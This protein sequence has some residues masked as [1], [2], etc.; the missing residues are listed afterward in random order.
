MTPVTATFAGLSARGEG[1]FGLLAS[2]SFLYNNLWM[3]NG[4]PQ[5]QELYGFNTSG[6]LLYTIN[7]PSYSTN[8]YTYI[9]AAGGMIWVVSNPPS[10][11]GLYLYSV[12]TSGTVTSYL[13]DASVTNGNLCR[14]PDGNIWATAETNVYKVNTSGTVLTSYSIGASPININYCLD[15]NF[16]LGIN[17]NTIVKLTT[18][19]TVTS[20]STTY[21]VVSNA[22][23]GIDG[24]IYA[25]TVNLVTT[26]VRTINVTHRYY[27]LT[28][29]SPSG[30]VLNNWSLTED[31]NGY[32]N[33]VLGADN[34]IWVCFN[35][36]NISAF[37]TSGTQVIGTGI[38]NNAY[39]NCITLGSDNRIWVAS[40]GGGM[41]YTAAI[42][43]SGTITYYAIDKAVNDFSFYITPGP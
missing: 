42:N 35:E 15:G 13:I 41:T 9:C 14:G 17:S 20:Y 27:Y 21:S 5:A 11:G 30:T 18:S 25:I 1:L 37:N 31:G 32:G 19:G 36:N 26:H 22:L 43:T 39:E 40:Y 34:N 6:S 24:N 33:I 2:K 12:T 8:N 7:L 38:T 29:M 10:G 4:Y 23:V 16:W 3:I 28:Q